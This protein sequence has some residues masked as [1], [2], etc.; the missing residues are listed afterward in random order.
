MATEKETGL[1]VLASDLD[2][3]IRKIYGRKMSFVLLVSPPESGI[4]D[5]IGNSDREDVIKAMRETATRLE[6]NEDMPPTE[7]GEH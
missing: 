7:G 4:A 5:Y 1:Q 3:K 6:N 2:K